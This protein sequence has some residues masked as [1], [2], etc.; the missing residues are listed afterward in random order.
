MTPDPSPVAV[1]P[2]RRALKSALWAVRSLRLCA[3]PADARRFRLC[4]RPGGQ[5][6]GSPVRLR[7]R[8]I[9]VPL[10]CRPGT[11]DAEV[12]WDTFG[13]GYHRPPHRLPGGATILDL[14]ANVGYTAVDFAVRYPEARVVAVELDRDNAALAGRNLEPFGERCTL[15]RAAIWSSDGEVAYGGD[16][17]WG[18]HV[19]PHGSGTRSAPAV[20]IATLLD[21][22]GL[23]RVDYV[24]MDI[25][26][27]E[28]EAL[29]DPG[30]MER[31][32]AIKVEVHPP[33]TFELCEQALRSAG[34]EVG[35]DRRHG[36]CVWG[37]RRA[38]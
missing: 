32:D 16:E 1:S 29:S 19:T 13:E 36:E 22:L 37:A 15:L 38:R 7:V 4:R 20:R 34:F 23:G 9:P 26:G 10:L 25:E 3:T 8:G 24:K 6:S 21:R 14:G 11:S 28:A 33:A 30:W 2:A 17:A 31:V 18:L 12:L 35:R 27:G 5:E